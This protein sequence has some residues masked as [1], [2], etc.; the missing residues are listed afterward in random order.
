MLLV[1]T[2]EE[3]TILTYLLPVYTHS[4]FILWYSVWGIHL[5]D[6]LPGWDGDPNVP[7]P[8][9]LS[10]H[11]HQ[12]G[13][14]RH[15]GYPVVHLFRWARVYFFIF[16]LVLFKRG[17]SPDYRGWV[18]VCGVC[19]RIGGVGDV[20]VTHRRQYACVVVLAARPT[21]GWSSFKKRQREDKVVEEVYDRNIKCS[22]TS[23]TA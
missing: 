21:I 13:G 9:P 12:R 2:N 18:Q 19:H 5:E 14:A 10:R 20:Q 16:F 6:E 8:P 7:R 11:G 15:P 22:D 17:V 23:L 4:R 1:L 3:L